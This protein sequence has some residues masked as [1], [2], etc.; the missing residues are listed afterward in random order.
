MGKGEN[1]YQGSGEEFIKEFTA[2]C[3]K[4]VVS[5]TGSPISP[6]HTFFFKDGTTCG[7]GYIKKR[8]YS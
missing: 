6:M 3:K 7:I 8:V 5:I 4:H 1:N 2:L